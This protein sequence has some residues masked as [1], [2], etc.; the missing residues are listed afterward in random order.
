MIP[1]NTLP[2][3]YAFIETS[4]LD[5]ILKTWSNTEKPP[6]PK[7]ADIRIILVDIF[8]DVIFAICRAPFVSS[9]IPDIKDLQKEKSLIPKSLNRG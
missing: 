8:L 5:V 1:C 9:I 3:K 6:N 4:D 7:I 2:I